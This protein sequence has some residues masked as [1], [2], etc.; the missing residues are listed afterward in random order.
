M[1]EQ[2]AGLYSALL[3]IFPAFFGAL[4]IAAILGIGSLRVLDGALT[5]GSLVALQSLAFSFAEPIK[6]L[7]QHAGAFQAV[8]AD[9]ARIE[10]VFNYPV[11]VPTGRLR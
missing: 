9:L 6:G 10:D 1:L 4:T 7:V 3:E 5:I 11:D 2:R 8:K